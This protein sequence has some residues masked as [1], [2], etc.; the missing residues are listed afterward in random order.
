[1]VARVGAVGR[2][3]ALTPPPIERVEISG[4]VIDLS[5]ATAS[6]DGVVAALTA[7]E[8]ELVRWLSARPARSRRAASSCNTC[9]ACRRRAR[10]VRS[11]SRSRRSPRSSSAIRHRRRSS[12]PCAAAIAGANSYKRLTFASL[13]WWYAEPRQPL[14]PVRCARPSLYWHVDLDAALA[15]ARRTPAGAV[16]RL[17]G[18]LDEEHS[19]NSRC[20]A[21]CSIPSRA[22]IGCCASA[23]C[24]T[25][26]RC[27]R[28]R[29]R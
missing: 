13:R 25:G 18:R 1:M 26:N 2:R 3:A 12:C 28:C 19:A 11:A 7:R 17:L 24:C 8:V 5:A 23:S 27:A 15:E 22:S 20:F 6:R 29:K 14:S 9:G 21:A 16:A 4:C 10:R